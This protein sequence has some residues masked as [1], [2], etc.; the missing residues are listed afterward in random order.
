MP[1][2]PIF[3]PA[4]FY[5][6]FNVV[7]RFAVTERTNVEFRWEVFNLFNTTAFALPE[8]NIYDSNFGQIA[9]TVNNPRLMQFALKL[10]F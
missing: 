3:G 1:Q 4:R 6:D 9:A 5:F 8:T 10:N 2:T 7:K